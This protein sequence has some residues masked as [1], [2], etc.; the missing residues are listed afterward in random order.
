[1]N[2]AAQER[3]RFWL[4]NES[5][6]A[7]A[8]QKVAPGGDLSNLVAIVADMRDPIA[9]LLVEAAGETQGLDVAGHEAKIEKKGEIPT[10][11][12]ILEV[13]VVEGLMNVLDHPAVAKVLARI[14]PPGHVRAIVISA[15]AAMLLHPPVVNVPSA[16]QS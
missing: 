1:M 4:A 8:L 10:A 9:R 6:A 7:M 12:M 14:P 16:G 5:L 2:P 3:F 13:S 11:I 15:G